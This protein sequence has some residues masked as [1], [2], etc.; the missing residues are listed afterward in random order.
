[1]LVGGGPLQPS[2]IVATETAVKVHNAGRM[3]SM[4]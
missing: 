3:C 4:G 1:V 2:A